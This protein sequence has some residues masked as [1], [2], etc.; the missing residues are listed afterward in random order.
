LASAWGPWQTVN[1]GGCCGAP[2]Y[3]H[4]TTEKRGKAKTFDEANAQSVLDALG[5]DEMFENVVVYLVEVA[6]ES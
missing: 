1:A 3:E 6:C 5:R 2:R 4:K